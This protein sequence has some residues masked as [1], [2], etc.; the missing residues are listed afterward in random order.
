MKR[1]SILHPLALSFY[2]KDL[3]RDV[4]QQ[5]R[6]TGFLYLLLL[7][8]LAWIPQTIKVH[9]GFAEWL[10]ENAP[11]FLLQVPPISIR[12]GEVFTPVDTPYVITSNTGEAI[13]IID[14][15]GQHTDL[16]DTSAVILVTQDKI[17]LKQEQRH[18]TRMYDLGQVQEFSLDRHD[19]ER[20]A[21]AARKWLWL[22]FYLIVVPSE[23]VYRILQALLYAAVELLFC[24]S[25]KISL[26]YLTLVR[27]A[28][29]AVT[30]V[31]LL[32]T[33]LGLADLRIPGAFLLW[34]GLALGY[35]YFGVKANAEAPAPA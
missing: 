29:I 34:L 28:V 21:V 2:S 25:L 20:W 13:A 17:L 14:L 24:Q 22:G 26:E 3:Y 5:W 23:F 10:D 32:Q 4:A 19:L 35:L 12:N 31:I 15:T 16:D 33:A 8:A 6:G 9:I 18:E 11:A 27:L 7:L 30:P 1:Y